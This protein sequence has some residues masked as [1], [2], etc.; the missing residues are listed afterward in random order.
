MANDAIKWLSTND[1][2]KQ[3]AINWPTGATTLSDNFQV[4]GTTNF[5]G[6]VKI[7]GSTVLSGSGW[8]GDTIPVNKGGTSATSLSSGYALIGNGTSAVNVREIKNNTTAGDLG[9]VS[10]T[11]STELINTNTLAYWNGEYKSGNS[12]LSKLSTVT[13]GTWEASPIAVAYGGTG[14]TN[15]SDALSALGGMPVAMS[16]ATTGADLN[17]FTTTGIYYYNNNVTNIPTGAGGSLLVMRYSS[18]YYYQMAFCNSSSTNIIP[19][20]YIRLH[21]GSGWGSWNKIAY[22]A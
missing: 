17:D 6:V 2:S 16:T 4:N 20:I 22:Q 7:N 9:W 13:S 14:A 3:V 1:T 5:S 18:T 8:A 21:N 15:A 11:A 19:I 12:N 10:K